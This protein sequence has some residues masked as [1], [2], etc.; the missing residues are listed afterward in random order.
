MNTWSVEGFREEGI[1]TAELGWGTHEKTL[2]PLAYEHADGPRNQICLARMGM[3]TWVRSW[4]PC[5]SIRGMVIRHGEAFTISDRLTVW[6]DN[7]AVYR[8][9]VHYAYCPCDAAIASLNELRGCDYELQSKQRIMTD[10]VV[11]G[12]DILGALVMGHAY[13][14]WWTGSILSIEHARGLLPHQNATTLQVAISVVAAACWSIQNP[15]RGLL[16]PDDLPH[17]FVL[18]IAKPYLGRWVSAR[19]DWTPLKGVRR[20]FG[21]Y[22]APQLASDD[23]WQFQNFLV[24]ERD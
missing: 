3:N 20:Y 6:E 24:W 9:T 2:P 8:P 21:P 23:P 18:G 17:D 22:G 19:S 12:A 1:T 14:S 7:Q 10:E 15:D 16:V 11:C 5:G 13:D 4:V